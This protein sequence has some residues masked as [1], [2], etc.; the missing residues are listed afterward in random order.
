MNIE[1]KLMK[2]VFLALILIFMIVLIGGVFSYKYLNG[3]DSIN[4][5]SSNNKVAI[6]SPHPDDETIGMG[7]FIQRLESEGKEVHVVVMC[8]G[9][10]IPNKV[11]VENYY[12][13]TIPSNATQADRKK[14]IREDAFVRVMNIYGVSYEIIGH[15]DSGTTDDDVFSVME[16]LRKEGYGEFYTTTGDY[17]V[18]HQHCSNGMALMMGKYP[19]LKYR[20][21]PV[22]WHATDNG[23]LYIPKPIVNI[24][25]DYNVSQYLPKK[26]EAL[27]VYY[28][29]QIFDEGEYQTDIERIYYV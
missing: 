1:V 20:Q 4:N 3:N 5:K 22:Y 28:N 17:N 27:N 24:H 8:S 19:S 21:F 29:I 18:D 7:G 25:T 16:R 26:L 14:L 6:I 12:N 23:T 11:R 13:V 15:N 10:G 2:K 9:N